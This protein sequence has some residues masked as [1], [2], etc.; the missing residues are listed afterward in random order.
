MFLPW[1]L[2]RKGEG[3][4]SVAFLRPSRGPLRTVPL[5]RGHWEGSE[6]CLWSLIELFAGKCI[7]VS[8]YLT[9]SM[10]N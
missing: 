3:S 8:K 7:M 1:P 4:Q 6:G 2:W 5:R 10:I 9:I